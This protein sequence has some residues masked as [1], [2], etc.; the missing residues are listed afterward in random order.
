LTPV[1]AHT[2]TNPD[3]LL[4][5]IEITRRRDYGL[6]KQECNL[7]VNCIAAPVRDA[8]AQIVAAVSVSTIGIEFGGE[9]F[10]DI[11]KATMDVGGQISKKL[12]AP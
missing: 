2:I 8:N 7:L 6:D 9:H 3:Q 12:G 1:T 4:K 5:E 10:M 11:V